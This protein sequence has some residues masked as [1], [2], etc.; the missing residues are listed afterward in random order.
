MLKKKPPTF[1]YSKRECKRGQW[2]ISMIAPYQQTDL[3]RALF[4][5]EEAAS[6]HVCKA[7]SNCFSSFSFFAMNL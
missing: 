3:P 7:S 1:H 2:L 4:Y 6:S 5:T